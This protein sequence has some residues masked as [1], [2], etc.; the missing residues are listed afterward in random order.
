MS[1]VN[2][3]Q[4]LSSSSNIDGVFDRNTS[5]CCFRGTAS[6][7]TTESWAAPS[8]S[9]LMQTTISLTH[10]ANLFVHI[11]EAEEEEV[12]E[13]EVEEEEEKAAV[14]LERRDWRSLASRQTKFMT[15]IP[16]GI[17]EEWTRDK[18]DG[19][20]NTAIGNENVL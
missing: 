7:T 18:V 14:R 8:T 1:F 10:S 17:S 20:R 15:N 11:E 5:K 2:A 12:E 19:E 3:S 9:G 6:S 4:R 16:P 13:E